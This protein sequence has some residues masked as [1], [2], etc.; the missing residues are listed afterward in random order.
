MLHR[1][2]LPIVIF[3]AFVAG[4][5]AYDIRVSRLGSWAILPLLTLMK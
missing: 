4:A 5:L 3:F 2:A 1:K